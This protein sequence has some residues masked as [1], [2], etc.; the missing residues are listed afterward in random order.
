MNIKNFS[1]P[2]LLDFLTV[3]NCGSINRA[4][5]E[6]NISQPALTRNLK[7]LEDRLGARLFERSHKGVR[8]TDAGEL[9]LE[10][11]RRV[12]Q[13]L[14]DAV[15]SLN[16]LKGERPEKISIGMSPT[17]A[18]SFGPQ[19][20]IDMLKNWG[21]TQVRIV[22]SLKPHLLSE[23][24]S[25]RIDMVATVGNPQE[26]FE[27]FDTEYLFS[28]EIGLF[29]RHGHPAADLDTFS[30]RPFKRM[31]WV[32]P[33]SQAYILQRLVEYMEGI[34]LEVSHTAI[35]TASISFMKSAVTRSERIAI[36]PISTFEDELSRGQVVRLKGQ[37]PEMERH[38]CLYTRRREDLPTPMVAARTLFIETM[39][40]I[41]K[42]RRLRYQSPPIGL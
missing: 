29:A 22:E 14:R 26:S 21:D 5:S 37:W 24:T 28:D 15:S 35:Y 27:E 19:A 38:F 39:R 16:Q 20:V 40:D 13:E 2:S 34:G 12:E 36:A 7:R 31:T 32:L 25:G 4:A 1:V 42:E 33:D 11:G 9:L 30:I 3:A 23:L 17:M 8:L 6:L 18:H 10:H 41:A